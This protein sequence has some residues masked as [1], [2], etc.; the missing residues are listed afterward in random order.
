MITFCP[1]PIPVVVE[2]LGDAIVIYV[3]ENPI[4][5]NDEICVALKDGGQWRHVT[6]DKIKSWSNQTYN[7]NKKSRK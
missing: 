7:I 2:E 5:D 4:W 6:T 3:K 1:I